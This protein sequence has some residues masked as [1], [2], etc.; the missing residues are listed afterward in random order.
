MNLN[1]NVKFECFSQ[2][3]CKDGKP[4]G[5]NSKPYFSNKHSKC[6]NDIML[7]KDRKLILKNQKKKIEISIWKILS[8]NISTTLA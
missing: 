1:K 6:D 8:K 7:N 4:F 2:Y 5:V 3:D